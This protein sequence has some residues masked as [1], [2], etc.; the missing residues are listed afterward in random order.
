MGNML[1]NS[2]TCITIAKPILASEIV[3]F[4]PAAHSLFLSDGKPHN[5]FKSDTFQFELIA[6]FN[7]VI[8]QELLRQLVL[9]FVS[10][11]LQSNPNNLTF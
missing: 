7:Y 3:F 1:H 10:R 2:M 11:S 6:N 5:Q 9:R 4:K 8:F